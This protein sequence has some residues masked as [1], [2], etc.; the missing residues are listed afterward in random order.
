MSP[1]D[2]LALPTMDLVGPTVDDDIRRAIW[3]YGPQAVKEAVREATK[4]KRG[5]KREPDWS[6][7]RELIEADARDWLAGKDPFAARSNYAIA[8][9]FSERMPGQSAISTHKRIE[10][11]LSHGP[12]DRRWYTLVSAQDQSRMAGSYHRYLRALD[13]LTK[14]QEPSHPD[15]WQAVLD[16]AR[17]TIA[18][19]QAREGRPPPEEMTYQEIED[20]VKSLGLN[21]LIAKPQN[22]GLF[23]GRPCGS[24]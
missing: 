22:R 2:A 6:E 4:A 20:T 7:L 18:D 13:A 15:L 24:E 12:H 10:R 14:L 16:R 1:Q 3:R 8:K 11:K 17:A 23:G 19:F 21:A 9:E 5:R